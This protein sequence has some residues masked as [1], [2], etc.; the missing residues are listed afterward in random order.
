MVFI[1][2][3]LM[4]CI[5]F[6]IGG[7]GYRLLLL[8][9]CVTGADIL[10][11]RELEVNRK[12]GVLALFLVSYAMML[13]IQGQIGMTIISS[14]IAFPFMMWYW[15]RE[16]CR[17]SS[18]S[19]KNFRR[20]CYIIF[21]G[22][23][24]MGLYALIYSMINDVSDRMNVYNIWGGYANHNSGVQQTIFFLLPESLILYFIV[25]GGKGRWLGLLTVFSA[26]VN[27]LF[28]AG[29]SGFAIMAI[30]NAAALLFYLCYCSRKK[31][32]IVIAIVCLVI[33]VFVLMFINDTFGI[34]S[35]W[36][37]S[38]MYE[39]LTQIDK[40]GDSSDSRP[41]KWLKGLKALA[42]SPF[43]SDYRYAHN[44]WIDMALEGGC[45][46][47]LLLIIY[48]AMSFHSLLIFIRSKK[49]TQQTRV[50]VLSIYVGTIASFMIEP[51]MQSLPL[52]VGNLFFL[53][54]AI[55]EFNLWSTDKM[56][57]CRINS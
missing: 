53:D 31:R 51:M 20:V 23:F 38:N 42:E 6:N 40:N 16:L 50:F 47:G 18:H 57:L 27:T 30:A 21:S 2:E 15:G 10:A 35:A 44:Y 54:S 7:K 39:R 46:T 25:Y 55:D 11:K 49:I 22:F 14:R 13:T 26:I 41:E 34:A 3:V 52:L 17:K 19:E 32:L 29:R 43:G 5:S 45:I 37:N 36:Q 4:F 8:L 33:I 28:F 9:L 48:T 12:L 1:V 56:R 24:L